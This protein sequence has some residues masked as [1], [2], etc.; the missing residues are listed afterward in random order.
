MAIFINPFPGQGVY[1]GSITVLA[2]PHNPE[3]RTQDTPPSGS[4]PNYAY[5]STSN[6]FDTRFDDVNFYP[7]LR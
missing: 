7:A 3:Y 2:S 5:E 1:G 6:R 4:P